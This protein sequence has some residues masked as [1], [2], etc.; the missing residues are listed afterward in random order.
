MEIVAAGEKRKRVFEQALRPTFTTL[1]VK[2]RYIPLEKLL[3]LA[4]IATK[5][6]GGINV[7]VLDAVDEEITEQAL[8]NPPA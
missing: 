6:G 8:A 1:G 3:D 5:L 4:D 2:A 7:K